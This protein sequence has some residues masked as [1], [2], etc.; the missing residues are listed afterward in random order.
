MEAHVKCHLLQEALHDTCLSHR[1]I[2]IPPLPLPP[3]SCAFICSCPTSLEFS[4]GV[5]LP[6]Y[7]R[8]VSLSQP[9]LQPTA[10]AWHRPAPHPNKLVLVLVPHR[11]RAP[12][13]GS[14]LRHSPLWQPRPRPRWHHGGETG[15]RG[16]RSGWIGV[17]FGPQSG[18]SKPGKT[19]EE[20]V[21]T[22]KGLLEQRKQI[23]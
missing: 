12:G 6:I 21:L 18:T 3:A 16:S 5:G 19:G 2:L 22:R 23:N 7:A 15:T 4:L 11:I 14:P 20:K 1:V 9:C 8:S 13:T 10:R 17:Y